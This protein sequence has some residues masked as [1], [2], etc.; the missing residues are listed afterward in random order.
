MSIWERP[1]LQENKEAKNL[2]LKGSLRLI[3]ILGI[4]IY[5]GIIWKQKKKQYYFLII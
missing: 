2:L 4:F 1:R 5:K 3:Q